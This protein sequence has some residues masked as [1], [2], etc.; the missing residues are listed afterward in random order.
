MAAT[1]DRDT[2]RRPG[3][4][5]NFPM[6]A[7]KVYAGTIACM[8]AAGY[9]TKGITATTLITL[10]VF[11]KGVDNAAGA[12][13]DLRGDVEGGVWGPFA[14]SAS[15]DLITLTE[16]GKDC[17]IVDD[18]TV[19]KTSGSSTRSIAGKVFDVDADG[20]WLSFP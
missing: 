4:Q 7:V 1:V 18:V 11:P 6:A 13:G 20:V 8:N 9:L 10:G 19:A 3:R 5:R 14:N 17:Y 16:V 12:A 2:K 15:G